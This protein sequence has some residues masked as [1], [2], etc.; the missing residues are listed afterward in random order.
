MSWRSFTCPS[1]LCPNISLYAFK[2]TSFCR[3]CSN[4]WINE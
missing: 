2:A 4:E 1:N 3:R